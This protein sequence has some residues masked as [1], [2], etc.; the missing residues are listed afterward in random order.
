MP[1]NHDE[2]KKKTTQ[3]PNQF[4]IIS[5][6]HYE[7]FKSVPIFDHSKQ[8]GRKEKKKSDYTLLPDT[9]LSTFQNWTRV[10]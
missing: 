9:M 5:T 6:I 8:M 3:P 7:G 4:S 10:F 1:N 2:L